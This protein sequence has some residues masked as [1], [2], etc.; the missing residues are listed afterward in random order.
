MTR[1]ASFAVLLCT[2]AAL[3]QTTIYVPDSNATI[4]TCNAIPMS[5]SFG[6]GS[7]T[8]IGRIPAS[9][10]DPNNRSIRDIE[11]A[12]CAAGTFTA[13]NIQIGI[14]HVPNPV[15]V[16]FTFPSFDVAGMPT[17]LGSFTDYTPLYNSVIQGPFT[18][19]MAANAW[20]PLG[21]ASSATPVFLWNGVDD[22]A[23][24]ITY[25]GA[26]GGGSCHRTTTEPFR[27]YASGSYQAATSAGSGA[28]GAKIGLVTGWPTPCGGCGSVALGLSGSASIGNSLTAT[29]SNLGPGVPFLGV[30]TAPFCVANYCPG[31]TIGHNWI[32]ALFGQSATLV[33][34]NDPGYIGL[35]LAFQGIGLLSPGGCQ[36][37]DLAFTHTS[38]VTIT[39]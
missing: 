15:P 17:A 12:P 10:L 30:G 23:F 3:A 21:L 19:T 14:G 11:F 6:A 28:A 9:L 32:V 25:G 34:P 18:W 22:I 20:S 29:I 37:P 13:P 35:Q 33:I 31:C 8:Y 7:M 27:I 16:P 4:G 2:S 26:T 38:V 5:A 39:Q 1:F 24:F 36:G